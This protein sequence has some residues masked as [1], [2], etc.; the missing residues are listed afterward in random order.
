MDM[1]GNVGPVTGAGSGIGRATAVMLAGAG[2]RVGV[3]THT[4]D[5]A[6]QA[7]EE[8]RGR[9]GEAVVPVADVAD[10]RQMQAAVEKLV[11]ACGRLNPSMPGAGID[12]EIWA[13]AS[14]STPRK[15]SGRPSTAG[16][17]QR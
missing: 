16:Q 3:L 14:T 8:I 15:P 9:G 4:E 5:E 2:A 11:S 17:D 10:A 1:K 12:G 13:A 6:P 7:A